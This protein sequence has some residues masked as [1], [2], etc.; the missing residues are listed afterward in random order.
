MDTT[1]IS[2]NTP[3]SRPTVNFAKRLERILG[4][5]WKVALPFVLPMVVIMIG[6]VLYPFI[7]AVALSTTRLNFLTGETQYVGL[8]N[9]ENLL[10]NSD[11][12]L[13]MQNTIRFTAWSLTIKFIVG[14]TIALLLNSKLPLRNVITAIMLLPWIVP[15]IVTAL[16]WKSIFDPLFGSLN[17]ILQGM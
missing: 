10:D 16:A 7:N 2:L 8:K 1:Q 17:P 12:I 15:E 9:Y 6:L 3:V 14:M 11:Y 4:R 5:D 13:S